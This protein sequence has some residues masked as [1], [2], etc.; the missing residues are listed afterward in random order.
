MISYLGTMIVP[1]SLH[2]LVGDYL[3]A[4]IRLKHKGVKVIVT[5]VTIG[6]LSSIVFLLKLSQYMKEKGTT[7]T[8]YYRPAR[9]IDII[10]PILGT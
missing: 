2:C 10:V 8:S 6:Q 3:N 7:V 1:H 5:T 4:G 9:K